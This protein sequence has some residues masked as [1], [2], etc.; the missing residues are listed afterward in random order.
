MAPR[1]DEEELGGIGLR[2]H[3]SIEAEIAP[4]IGV[5]PAADVEH[6]QF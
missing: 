6:G 2:S 4:Q 1:A 5:I 3:L